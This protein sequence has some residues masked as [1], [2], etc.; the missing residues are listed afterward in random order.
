MRFLFD[1]S[2]PVPLKQYLSEHEVR[3]AFD[4]GW[5][6]LSN[7]DLLEAAEGKFEIFVTADR[8]LRHQQSFAGRRLAVFVLPTTNWPR[9]R[10]RAAAVAAAITEMKPGEYHEISL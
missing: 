5:S 8:N 9:L 6:R 7:G 3:T 10:D 2:V 4:L 1:Q